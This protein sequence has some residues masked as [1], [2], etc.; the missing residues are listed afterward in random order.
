M[1]YQMQGVRPEAGLGSYVNQSKSNLLGRLAPSARSVASPAALQ[2]AL[3]SISKW[4]KRGGIG[5]GA[6]AVGT[7][8]TLAYRDG[9]AHAANATLLR[10]SASLYVGAAAGALLT[11]AAVVAGAPVIVGGVVVL[12]VAGGAAWL[13]DYGIGEVYKHY[14]IYN[15]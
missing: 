5:L 11:G 6:V 7:E 10:G 2:N 3:G 8:T 9:G 14:G 1:I 12:G 4:G 13:T 15:R